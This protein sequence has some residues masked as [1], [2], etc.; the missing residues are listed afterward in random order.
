MFSKPSWQTGAGVPNDASRDVPDISLSGSP[1]HD[2]FLVCSQSFF[3]GVTPAVSSCTTGFRASDG[4]SLAVVGG[5]SAGA[6]AFAGIVALLNQKTGSNGL[7]N[8]NPT[9]YSLASTTGAFHDITTGNNIVPCV[10]SSKGCPTAAP[11]QYGFS[12]GA[13]YDQVTGLGSVNVTNLANAWAALTPAPDFSVWG[14][15]ATAA[16]PGQQATSQI[17]LESRAGFN[18]IGGPHLPVGLSRGADHLFHQ[19]NLVVGHRGGCD[20]NDDDFHV[21]PH[22]A[23]R[24]VSFAPRRTASVG[25]RP[26]AARCLQALS[27]WACL[28]AAVVEWRDSVSCCWYFSSRAL[29]CGGG[30]SGVRRRTGELPQAATPSR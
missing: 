3:V 24:R 11:F 30:S 14:Y 6:P 2:G 22:V 28:R 25:W 16:A 18:G 26:A 5:T 29:G 23:I 19:S 21:A 8:V 20:R 13:G 12:A 7:G 10:Q 9:L 15:S 1:N 4:S 17:V 27:F